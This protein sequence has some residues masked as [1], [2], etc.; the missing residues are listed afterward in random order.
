MGYHFFY[1][2]KMGAA[3]NE[4]QHARGLPITDGL[5]VLS[6]VASLLGFGVIADCIHQHELNQI[7][8]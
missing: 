8:A 6:V 4:I 7:D 2:Y 5:P 3:V 1:Q